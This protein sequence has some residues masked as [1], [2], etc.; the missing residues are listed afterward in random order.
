MRQDRARTIV[1]SYGRSGAHLFGL[2][3]LVLLGL[4]LLSACPT[5]SDPDEP[6]QEAEPVVGQLTLSLVDSADTPVAGAFATLGPLGIEVISD[7]DGIAQFT[8]LPAATYLVTVAAVGFETTAVEAV[9]IVAGEVTEVE[10]ALDED[11]AHVTPALR[12]VASTAAGRALAGA[13]VRVDGGAFEATI[14]D[15]GRVSLGGLPA[16]D[17]DVQILAAADA[18]AAPWSATLHF[19]E[20]TVTLLDVTLSGVPSE[21]ATWLGSDSCTECHEDQH[22]AW[23]ASGHGSTWSTSPPSSLDPLLDE[24]L[25]TGIYLPDRPAPV[26]VKVWR[27]GDVDKITLFA[28]DATVTYDVL[29]WYGSTASIPL[30]DLPHGPVPAPV[31]WRA[32]GEGDLAS[33]AFEAGLIGFRT[34]EWFDSGR[35]LIVHDDT[36]GPAPAHFEAAACL[37]CH[38]VGFTVE[39]HHGRVTAASTGGDGQA[40]ERGVGCEACHGPGSEH[41]AAGNDDDGGVELIVNPRRLDPDAA[42]DVCGACHSEGVAAT[43]DDFDVEVQFPYGDDEPWRPG[44]A[45]GDY[46]VSAPNLW[47]GGA[48]AGPNQQVDELRASPHGGSGLYAL[49]CGECHATHGPA[50]DLPH[51]LSAD[52]DDNSLCLGCHAF[53]N[54]EDAAAAAAHTGHSGYDPTGPYAS[55]RC[56]GCHM[57]ATAS[58]AERSEL[59]GGGRLASHH[60]AIL[61]PADSLAAF[62]AV[63]HGELELDEVPPN[64]CLT[65][66]RWAEIRYE[67]VGVD[68]HG[69]AGEPTLRTTYVTL[70]AVYQLLFGEDG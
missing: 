60:F 49:G 5:T 41:V 14:G 67:A 4:P 12:V 28:T 11:G 48:A 68:F 7:A 29:G 37:G 47:P 18:P 23:T 31:I 26:D 44:A 3:L 51:Q 40:V 39:E 38:A 19:D 57:P 8:G 50:D 32:P 20:G 65:C 1:V 46:L 52:P 6:A 13:V 30:L 10:L 62:D 9:E 64:A 43:A 16:G 59:T 15:D 24:G 70:D 55:G 17:L 53:L 66:H 69:P 33:P 63:G 36:D 25:T 35:R 61:P 22:D 42:L 21:A 34:E 45:L 2:L 56:T 54:F 27:D 58:R